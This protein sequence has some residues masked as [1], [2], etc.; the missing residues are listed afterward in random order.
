MQLKPVSPP[1][2]D[3]RLLQVVSFGG[4]PVVM[5]CATLLV[6]QVAADAGQL[7]IGILAAGAVSVA[8]VIMG[9]VGSR[10]AIAECTIPPERPADG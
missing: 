1:W 5:V 3:R 9:I 7:A 6:R 2:F 10:P 4:A 8:L